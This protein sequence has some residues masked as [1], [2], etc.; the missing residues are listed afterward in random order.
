MKIPCPHCPRTFSTPNNLGRHM[1]CAHPNKVQP[2]DEVDQALDELAAAGAEIPIGGGTMKDPT[3]HTCPDCGREGLKSLAMHKR[4]CPGKAEEQELCEGCKAP[5]T[6]YD[7]EGIP[8]CQA[9]YDA[10]VADPTSYD[11]VEVAEAIVEQESCSDSIA[12]VEEDIAALATLGPT[13]SLL[14]DELVAVYWQL[15]EDALDVLQMS[16][17]DSRWEEVSTLLRDRAL[18]FADAKVK[19]EQVR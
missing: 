13:R 14:A 19:Q 6:K 9:C 2:V 3:L 18:L 4:Y 5:A 8:L 15:F 1:A 11:P 16:V 7:S 17:P 12:E 10:M